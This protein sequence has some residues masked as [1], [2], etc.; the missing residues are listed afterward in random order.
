M[1]K[2]GRND[3]CPCGS[4]KKYKQCCLLKKSF[5]PAQRLRRWLVSR[6]PDGFA[7]ITLVL[8]IIL[9]GAAY[10]N[11]FTVPFVFDDGSNIVH[12]KGVH[13][14]SLRLEDGD[15]VRLKSSIASQG[16]AISQISYALNYY[17]GKLDPWGYHLVNLIIHILCAWAVFWFTRLTLTLPSMRDRYGGWAREIA[18]GCA[19]IFTVHP[20]NTQAVTYIVQRATSLA[21]LFF[22]LCL[23]YYAKG[24]L[25]TG[26]RRYVYYLV[27]F[28]SFLISFSSKQNTVVMP[29]ILFLYEFYF[30]QQTD[31]KWLKKKLPYIFGIILFLLLVLVVH[32]KFEPLDWFL[33]N[34]RRRPF[35]PF[36]RVSTEWRVIIY[37]FTLLLLPLPS[38]L[39]L[40]YDFPLSYSLLNPPATLVSLLIIIGLLVLAV[41]L[42]K[43]EPLISF[44]IW[45]F[46]IN[47]AVEST[48]LALD[49]VYEHRLYLP[50]IGL[51]I[52]LVWGMERAIH[53]LTP[54]L[55][56]PLKI[57]VLTVLTLNLSVMTYQ[58][59]EVWQSVISIL[60]DVAKKAPT[61]ARQHVNLGVAY[62]DA[63]ML[64]KALEQYLIG[65][66][67]DPNYPEAYNNLGNAYNRKGM[68]KKA[69]AEYL[70]AIKMRPEYKEA[71]NN[72]GSA[73]CNMGKYD[74]AIKEHLTA[75]KINPECEKSHNN[76]GVAYSFKGMY[77]KAIVEYQRALEIKP[78]F[79]KARSNLG[80]A[81]SFKKM[82]DKAIEEYEKVLRI[83]PDD[84]ATNYNL[85]NIY[86]DRGEPR[87]AV[88]AF[89]R[90]LAVKPKYAEA[91]NNLGLAYKNLK[92]FSKAEAEI[93]QAIK[94]KPNIAEFHFNLGL[95]YKES[96]RY[97]KAEQAFNRA[98]QLNPAFAVAHYNLGAIAE[99]KRNYDLAIQKY[100]QAIRINPKFAPAYKSLGMIYLNNRGDTGQAL[101][102]LK[103]SLALAPAQ[104]NAA[105]LK[106][107]V[108]KLELKSAS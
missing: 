48:I 41:Y 28:V 4:G 72:L 66:K 16:R 85:G 62:S 102:L 5:S 10:Y 91:H 6:R 33:R 90:V 87:R 45:W 96:K 43:R 84:V 52:I 75:L 78:D 89:R 42:A 108:G 98:L 71:H 23:I 25:I 20:V 106:K 61:N 9:A 88:E 79:I 73:Y 18:A 15:L 94:L 8:I 49:L 24:R 2:V 12:N 34:Y 53:H 30:F 51:L 35:T 55:R 63:G 97:A 92:D 68:Y 26:S 11:S 3:P 81:Y 76:L 107:L 44:F 70:K 40:D 57:G 21:A 104:P 65:I 27:A 83:K 95:V 29:V 77:D 59:N 56:V 103:Q 60:E 54:H 82:Y 74:M 69:V 39:N 19:L 86:N 17:F 101:K 58:R 50:G 38:R 36:E 14:S 64:D 32:T 105:K 37:Y 100:Q 80:L 1:P 93:K 99:A 47:L 7:L 46:F 22:L 31:L 67:L 13:L